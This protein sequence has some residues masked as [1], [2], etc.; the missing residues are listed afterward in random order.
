MEPPGQ[1]EGP[2]FRLNR[3]SPRSEYVK[4]APERR[5]CP[6]RNAL[7]IL[8]RRILVEKFNVR[9]P[10]GGFAG[11]KTRFSFSEEESP[12]RNSTSGSR[13]EVL[14]GS[15]RASRFQ[16]KNL[17]RWNELLNPGR[18]F[19]PG[20]N[21]RFVSEERIRAEKSGVSIPEEGLDR[22]KTSLPSRGEESTRRNSASPSRR[23]DST[24]SKRTSRP[25]KRNLCGENERLI[26]GSRIRPGQN[27]P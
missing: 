10:R 12:G 9:I 8:G 22:V 19:G 25:G 18:R 3:P 5:F 16:R 21:E 1:A 2:P 26:S 24:G 7:L 4:P 17:L 14:P 23:K 27:R 11:D 13:E 20:Q 6:G 15:I